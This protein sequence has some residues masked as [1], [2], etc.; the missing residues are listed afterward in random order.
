VYTIL[1]PAGRPC[2]GAAAANFLTADYNAAGHVSTKMQLGSLEQGMQY[3]TLCLRE[4]VFQLLI[5]LLVLDG[6]GLASVA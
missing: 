5:Y 4:L 3:P 1:Q 2:S 6:D